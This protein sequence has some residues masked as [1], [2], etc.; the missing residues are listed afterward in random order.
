[1]KSA[2]FFSE[3]RRGE[4]A[5]A[6]ALGRRQCGGASAQGGPVRFR[7]GG[8]DMLNAFGAKDRSERAS[9][10]ERPIAKIAVEE[11]RG[12]GIA[13]SGGI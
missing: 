8:T 4:M 3:A 1:M 9:G 2:A 11:T 13:G 5:L 12:P 6:V 7:D 10:G